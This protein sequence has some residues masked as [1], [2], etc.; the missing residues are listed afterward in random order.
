M[1]GF[2]A[3]IL[4]IKLVA[5]A[6]K[7]TKALINR[8]GKIVKAAVCDVVASYSEKHVSNT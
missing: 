6:V 8:N 2:S 3:D 4:P 7:Q 5:R 1:K